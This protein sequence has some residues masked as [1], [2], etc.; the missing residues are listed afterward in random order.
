MILFGVAHAKEGAFEEVDDIDPYPETMIYF[1][2]VRHYLLEHEQEL[3]AQST[4]NLIFPFL[5]LHSCDLLHRPIA[6]LSCPNAV[7]LSLVLLTLP[8]PSHFFVSF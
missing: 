4:P 7:S 6:C 5:L 3:R 8:S 1:P 2:T